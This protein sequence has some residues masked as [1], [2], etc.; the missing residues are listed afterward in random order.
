MKSKTNFPKIDAPVAHI[1]VD[2]L[3]DFISGSLACAHAREAIESIVAQINANPQQPVFYVCDAHP[4]QHCSFAE[5]GGLWPVHCVKGTQGQNID[6]A[7]YAQIRTPEHQPNSGNIF[8]KAFTA[9][10]D[11]YSGYEAQD[12]EGRYLHQVLAPGQ[13]V[14]VS[15]IA[16]E[17]CVFETAKDFLKAGF[18]VQVLQDGLAYISSEGHQKTLEQMKEMGIEVV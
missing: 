15:G 17:Y 7:F 11:A 1:V 8:E 18:R 4:T 2:V 10:A 16:T 13:T 6:A 5:Q 3:Y 9:E 14:L 12:V